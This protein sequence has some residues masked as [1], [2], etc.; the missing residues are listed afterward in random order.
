MQCNLMLKDIYLVWLEEE[1]RI[2]EEEILVVKEEIQI[3]EEEIRIIMP[4][5]LH[6]RKETTKLS[7]IYYN[8][9]WK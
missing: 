5:N 1:I 9:N 6:F 3:I 4:T 2:I 7:L 8:Y